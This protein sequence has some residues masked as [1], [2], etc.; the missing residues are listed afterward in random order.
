MSAQKAP[1]VVPAGRLEAI[2]RAIFSSLGSSE[3]EAGLIARHLVEAN[4]RGHDSHGIGMIPAYVANGL[5]GHMVLNNSLATVL[6]SGTLLICDGG[7]GAGQVMAHDA[8]AL[9]IERAREH[10]SCILGLRNSHHIGRIGHWAEQSVAAGL[11]SI[12]F[13]NVVSEPAV[14]PFGGTQPRMGT[15]PFAIGIPRPG[16]DPIILDFAT[17]RWA[18]GKIRVA[19]NK[20]EAIPEGYLLDAQGRPTTNPGDLFTSPPGGL[21]T[22]GEHKGWGMSLACELLAAALTGG[23]TQTG[24]RASPAILNSMLAVIVSPDRLGTAG[25]FAESLENVV[26]WVQSEN[27]AGGAQVRL[28]GDPERETRARRLAEGIPVDPSTWDLV[29]TAGEQA[30][31]TR[32]AVD[33]IR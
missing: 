30:G 9:G 14:V 32:E 25:P 12:H 31:L 6:N 20:G 5:S 24:P 21:L 11:V 16:S 28:A 7:Q 29:L 22:F 8:M 10:G 27:G 2:V 1:V 4:L 18:V 33:A 13:V 23:K 19:F 15:N 26:R 17:S 3:R